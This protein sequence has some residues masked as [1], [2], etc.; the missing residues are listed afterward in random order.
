MRE[1]LIAPRSPWLNPYVER[2]IG[3]IRR[4]CLDHLIILNERHLHRVLRTYLSYYHTARTHLQP[5]P[6][7]S[8]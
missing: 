6:T 1:V 2:L 3:T 4:D 5:G 8:Q 7:C